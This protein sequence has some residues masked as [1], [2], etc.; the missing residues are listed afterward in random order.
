M[1]T[2]DTVAMGA[3]ACSFHTVVVQLKFKQ[4]LD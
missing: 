1:A 4:N 3:L 2:N